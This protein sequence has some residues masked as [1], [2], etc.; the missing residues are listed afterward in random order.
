[1][2]CCT[3]LAL[4]YQPQRA[5]AFAITLGLLFVLAAPPSATLAQTAETLRPKPEFAVA[6]VGGDRLTVDGQFGEYIPWIGISATVHDGVTVLRWSENGKDFRAYSNADFLLFCGPGFIDTDIGPIFYCMGISDSTG[7]STAEY[8]VNYNGTSRF[9]TL[10]DFPADRTVYFIYGEQPGKSDKYPLYLDAFHRYYDAHYDEL[11]Q[12]EANR[13]A[14]NQAR[15]E[16]LK[17]HPPPSSDAPLSLWL[18]KSRLYLQDLREGKNPIEEAKRREELEAANN[19]PR[20][21]AYSSLP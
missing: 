2:R 15:I 20:I 3:Q 16:Y 10:E 5:S 19:Q 18:E 11:V 7:L 12:A 17:L 8:P 13:D 6:N 14:E 1:M 21:A 9:P 4:R